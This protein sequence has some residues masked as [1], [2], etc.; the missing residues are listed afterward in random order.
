MVSTKWIYSLRREDLIAYASEFKFGKDG[1]VDELRKRMA[2]FIK[3]GEHK[4]EVVERLETLQQKHVRSTSPAPKEDGESTETGI[5]YVPT[6]S[7]TPPEIPR[8]TVTNAEGVVRA[9]NY[10]QVIE[11]VRK[12]SLKYDGSK[13]PLGFLERVEELAQ[14]YEIPL[15]VMPKTMPELLKDLAL[16]WFRNNNKHWEQWQNFR[17]D[18]LDFFLPSG[19]FAQLEDKIRNRKQQTSEPFK[20]YM[21]TLQDFMRQAGYSE[22]Q[23]LERLYENTNPNYRMYIKRPDFQNLEQ[24]IVLAGDFEELQGQ[25]A[26]LYPGP[27]IPITR[28]QFPPQISVK[29]NQEN[30][31]AV[32]GDRNGGEQT[33]VVNAADPQRACRR[34]GQS[35]HFQRFCR[36]EAKLFCWNCGRQN[37]RTVECC[38]RRTGNDSGLRQ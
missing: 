1:T 8:V 17:Q 20:T 37:V 35:G 3:N 7:A 10:L 36:N 26:A 2:D 33:A 5:S 14:V 11:H 13:N 4:P 19:Y 21:I 38:G 12:W 30:V 23:K 27:Q 9:G 18:F 16:S 31:A 24:L 29:R 34:C 15:D 32:T 22:E 25:K 6:L 28:P